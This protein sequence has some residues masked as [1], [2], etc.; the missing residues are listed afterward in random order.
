MSR[1][2]AIALLVDTR[3][4]LLADANGRLPAAAQPL[5]DTAQQLERLLLDVRACRIDS[6]ELTHPAPVQVTVSAD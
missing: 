1:R 4:K 6:F 2:S 5:H 3:K